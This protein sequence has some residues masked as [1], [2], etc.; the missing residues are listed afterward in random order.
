MGEGVLE[1]STRLCKRISLADVALHQK[2]TSTE[3]TAT[4][5]PFISNDNNLRLSNRFPQIIAAGPDDGPS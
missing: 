5:F 1:F 2:S 3:A 4:H